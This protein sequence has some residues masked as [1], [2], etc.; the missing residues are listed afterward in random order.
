MWILVIVLASALVALGAGLLAHAGGAATP[1]A[2]LV[3]G[4]AFGTSA[5]LLM[6]VADFVEGR[7]S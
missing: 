6:K 7:R 5:L 2:I 3:G 4:S 1:I